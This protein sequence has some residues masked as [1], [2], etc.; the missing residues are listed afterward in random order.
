VT[1][2]NSREILVI[3]HVPLSSGTGNSLINYP[4]ERTAV[5]STN[6]QS[7]RQNT[8]ELHTLS[9]FEMLCIFQVSGNPHQPVVF[10]V[11]VTELGVCLW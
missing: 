9:K 1:A 5:L 6:L 3:L 4:T 7:F 2:R 11:F 10:V 8:C